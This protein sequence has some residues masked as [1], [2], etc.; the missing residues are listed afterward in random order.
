M[1]KSSPY[2]PITN[3]EA[4]MLLPMNLIGACSL[5]EVLVVIMEHVHYTLSKDLIHKAHAGKTAI[6][7]MVNICCVHIVANLP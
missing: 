1:G 6:V 3:L 5:P 7:I 4:I 2:L